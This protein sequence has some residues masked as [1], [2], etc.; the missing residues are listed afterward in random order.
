MLESAFGIPVRM[1]FKEFFDALNDEVQQ[2]I[3]NSRSLSALYCDLF[4]ASD[5]TDGLCAYEELLKGLPVS[6]SDLIRARRHATALVKK[7]AYL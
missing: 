2:R 3:R 5:A 6:P 7:M 4:S 1:L